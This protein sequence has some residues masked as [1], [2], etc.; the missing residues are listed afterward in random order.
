MCVCWS[1]CAGHSEAK[2]QHVNSRTQQNIQT[3]SDG[4]IWFWLVSWS[5]GLDEGGRPAKGQMSSPSCL[6]PSGGPRLERVGLAMGQP[7]CH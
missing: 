2:L 3:V 7:R 5:W 4:G 6:R 1:V